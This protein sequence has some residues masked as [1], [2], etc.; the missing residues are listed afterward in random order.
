M[1]TDFQ[2]GRRHQL[3]RIPEEDIRDKA[4]PFASTITPG[5]RQRSYT[6][7]K[8][9][10][11]VIDQGPRMGSCV[12][13]TFIAEAAAS[14]KAW[15]LGDDLKAT[16]E[17]YYFECQANDSFPGGEYPGA[18]PFMQGTSIRAG[19]KTAQRRGMIGEYR[20]AYGAEQVAYA[21]GRGPVV[22]GTWWFEGMD[23]PDASGYILPDGKKLGGHAWLIIGVN[24]RLRRFE[25][26]NSWGTEWGNGGF[27]Y[28]TFNSVDF[29]LT[30][31]GEALV[32]MERKRQPTL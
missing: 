2:P 9:A 31:Q 7:M 27:A 32:I 22:M 6:W 5:Q 21:V 19:A 1:R 8:N 3:G 12:G 15:D 24:W 11:Q 25:M 30:E 17:H 13:C 26:L 20:W 10:I 29:L 28:L 4:F 16:A 18:S 23:N 14:P